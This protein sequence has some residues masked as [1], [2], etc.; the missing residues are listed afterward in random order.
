M[1]LIKNEFGSNK[2]D[3]AFKLIFINIH[4]TLTKN[5]KLCLIN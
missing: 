4:F 3:S 2:I 1:K 5:I